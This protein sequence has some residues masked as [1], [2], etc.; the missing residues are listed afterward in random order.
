MGEGNFSPD[1]LGSSNLRASK[2]LKTGQNGLFWKFLP[3]WHSE[4]QF[5]GWNQ[6]DLNQK[7][8]TIYKGRY[9]WSRSSCIQPYF[10]LKTAQN[11]PNR[12]VW[13]FL[14]IWHSVDQF[15]G[16]NQ[17]DLTKKSLTI[18]EGR[19]FS[20]DQVGSSYILASKVENLVQIFWIAK[21]GETIKVFF[22]YFLKLLRMAWRG[23]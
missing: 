7:S 10:G 22:K 8:L 23:F 20:P 9:F 14:P 19:Y 1:P 6:L 13:Q 12:L 11:G 17:L 15:F 3:I 4:D 2:Q 5:F 18:Y 21:I 16:W